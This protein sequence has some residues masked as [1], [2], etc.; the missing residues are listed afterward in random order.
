MIAGPTSPDPSLS[1]LLSICGAHDRLGA[2]VAE[3]FVTSGEVKAAALTEAD[4]ER[5]GLR[6]KSRKQ[7]LQLIAPPNALPVQLVYRG[8]FNTG[9]G[10]GSFDVLKGALRKLV[11]DELGLQVEKATVTTAQ[12]IAAS[13]GAIKDQMNILIR[14]EMSSLRYT[15][16]EAHQQTRSTVADAHQQTRST[17]A[18]ALAE[19]HQQTL[20]MLVTLLENSQ[21]LADLGHQS[22]ETL[23]SMAQ[24]DAEVPRLMT[25]TALDSAVWK[26]AWYEN[27]DSNIASWL[28][29]KAGISCSFRLHFLCAFHVCAGRSV[30]FCC[31]ASLADLENVFW[32]R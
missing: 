16:A 26:G 19:A 12:Q 22:F 5:L 13:T 7:L 6:M 20:G 31:S 18:E 23:R 25:I 2:F 27:T 8:D 10:D 1:S 24:G 9:L 14:D 21:R 11:V 4:L 28:K 15:V 17:V 3:G 29:S 32:R 30:L